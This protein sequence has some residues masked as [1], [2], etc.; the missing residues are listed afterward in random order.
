MEYLSGMLH[1][2]VAIIVV[3]YELKF[4]NYKFVKCKILICC[5]IE[6]LKLLSMLAVSFAVE[7]KLMRHILCIATK[8][9]PF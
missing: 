3:R 1:V 7:E 8:F 6:A 4:E 9:F 5:G 2:V